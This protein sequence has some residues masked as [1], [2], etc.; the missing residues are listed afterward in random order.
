[1]F[2]EISDVSKRLSE[3][4]THDTDCSTDINDDVFTSQV[5]QS[6]LDS[7]ATDDNSQQYSLSETSDCS[8]KDTNGDFDP[9]LIL[10]RYNT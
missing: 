4:S 7:I 9:T 10:Q 5:D 2:P 3:I 8:R 1:M 6:S